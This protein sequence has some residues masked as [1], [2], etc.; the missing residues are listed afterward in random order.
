[1]V[2]KATELD[3]LSEGRGAEAEERGTAFALL[4]STCWMPGRGRRAVKGD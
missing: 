3:K 4:L 2:F 1:M